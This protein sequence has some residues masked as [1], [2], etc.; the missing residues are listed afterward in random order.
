MRLKKVGAKLWIKTE[1]YPGN[2]EHLVF[3]PSPTASTGELST[4]YQGLRVRWPDAGLYLGCDPVPL[5]VA[6]YCMVDICVQLAQSHS[7]PPPRQ[8]RIQRS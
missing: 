7:P 8:C 3:L 1:L 2:K 6:D 5:A 4:P